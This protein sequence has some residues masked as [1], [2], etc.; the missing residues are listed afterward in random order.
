MEL[1]QAMGQVYVDGFVTVRGNTV[2]KET[3]SDAARNA[4]AQ[5]KPAGWLVKFPNGS[6]FIDSEPL[7]RVN[8]TNGYTCTPLYAGEPL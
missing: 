4:L 5:V 3:S 2:A 8:L 7:M 1:M 6:V